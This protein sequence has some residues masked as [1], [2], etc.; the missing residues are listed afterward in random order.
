MIF[1]KNIIFLCIS[2]LIYSGFYYFFVSNSDFIK[3]ILGFH[4]I[5]FYSDFHLPTLVLFYFKSII[6]ILIIFFFISIFVNKNALNNR[7]NTFSAFY[8][9]LFLYLLIIKGINPLF[10]FDLSSLV[11]QYASFIIH[12]YFSL[13]ELIN[14]FLFIPLPILVYYYFKSNILLFFLFLLSPIIEL[15]QLFFN[16]GQFDIMDIIYNS[17]GIVIGL[18]I[19]LIFLKKNK[20]HN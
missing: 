17:I 11:F 5:N 16:I 2:I 4:F 12:P 10:V 6:L 20:N 8:A 3:S 18:I 9:L 13:Q 1:R 19:L 14:I 7:I 15:I